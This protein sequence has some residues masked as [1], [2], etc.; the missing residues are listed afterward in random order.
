MEIGQHGRIGRLGSDIVSRRA[1]EES[2]SWLDWARADRDLIET[3][4]RL[5]ALR[6]AHPALRDD[7]FLDG[8]TSDATSPRD[9]DWLRADGAPMREED[10]RDMT[11]YLR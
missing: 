4:A 10:W 8:G 9:V 2:K 6:K 1:Y 5:V 7:R 3:A 11:A